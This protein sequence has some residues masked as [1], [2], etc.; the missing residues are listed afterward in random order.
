M[1]IANVDTANPA[2]GRGD[3]KVHTVSIA[4]WAREATTTIY[5][6]LDVIGNDAAESAVIEFPGAGTSGVVNYVTIAH[7]ETKV[8]TPRLFVFDAAPTDILDNA[9]LALVSSDLAKLV[10][11]YEFAE[12]D[13]INVGTGLEVYIPS[14]SVGGGNV[15][16]AHASAYNTTT[17]SLY[18]LLQTV[19]GYTPTASIKTTIR[20]QLE[21]T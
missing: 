7:E 13:K 12:S 1:V 4:S 15:D 2:G 11:V 5:T 8:I 20:L 10:A 18:G 17:G 19:T 21:V 16:L 9:A 6:A 14:V 3:S